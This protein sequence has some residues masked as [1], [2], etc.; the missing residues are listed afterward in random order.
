MKLNHSHKHT[1]LPRLSLREGE[2]NISQ[3]RSNLKVLHLVPQDREENVIVGQEMTVTEDLFLGGEKTVFYVG[4]RSRD[5]ELN[6]D[7]CLSEGKITFKKE[8][9]YSVRVFNPAI[10][11][12]DNRMTFS[13]NNPQQ[14][15]YY[16]VTEK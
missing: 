7:Y 11:P 3:S 16:N 9:S 1:L 12:N 2:Y 14:I 8:G 6:V 15:N 10:I 4:E 5:I 13:E